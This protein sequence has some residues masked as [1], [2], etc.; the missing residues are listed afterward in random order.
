MGTNNRRQRNRIEDKDHVLRI[1]LMVA[2]ALLVIGVIIV[3]IRLMNPKEDTEKGVKKLVI[4]EEKD[5]SEVDQKIQA[6]EEEERLA[7]EEWANRPAAEKFV[8]CLL[9][10]DSVTQGLY[11][12]SI[13][14]QSLVQAERGAGVAGGKDG[15]IETHIAKALEIKPQKLFLAYGMNDIKGCNGDPAVFREKYDAVIKELKAGLPETKIY[16]NSILPVKESVV[17]AEPVYGMVPE[18]NAQLQQMCEKEG[19]TYIDNTGLVE[20]AF[21]EEDGI[22]MS[23]DYYTKWVEHM[24]E[25]AKL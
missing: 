15:I 17:E 12:Y 25:V 3:V 13:L 16:V 6:L 4:M 11:E 9:L 8:N 21:Y 5:V 14:D 19:L 7:D 18:F 23:P 1:A 2:A 24:A 22:H 20:E 10:G